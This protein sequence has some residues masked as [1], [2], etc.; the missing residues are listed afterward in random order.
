M[1]GVDLDGLSTWSTI[2][3]ISEMHG[4]ISVLML[5][6]GMDHILALIFKLESVMI[7]IVTASSICMIMME[8]I[9]IYTDYDTM[10]IFDR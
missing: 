4:Y 10:I 1:W 3:I 7:L 8:I 2:Q 9:L 5:F 6:F